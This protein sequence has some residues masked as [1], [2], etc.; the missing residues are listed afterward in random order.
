[1]ALEGTL[2]DFSLPDIFQLISLQRKSGVLTLKG[3]DDIVTVFFKD[4]NILAADSQQER[5]EHRL[6]YYLV[7]AKLLSDE[8]LK[9][10][11]D[12]QKE[13]LQRLGNILLSY[14]FI[15][16]EELQKTLQ[17]VITQKIYKLFR[18]RDGEYHFDP[19][20][21][22][23]F[24]D[25]YFS[26]IPAQGILMEA[27]RMIDEWPLIERKIPNTNIIFKKTGK[28]LQ[29]DKAEG[30]SLTA[31]DLFGD[32][33][34]FSDLF[35]A[36]KSEKVED[37]N[38]EAEDERVFRFIDGR[39]TIKDIMFDAQMTDFDVCHALNS[40][41][42]K[43]LI[44][45]LEQFKID[46]KAQWIDSRKKVEVKFPL[47]KVLLPIMIAAMILSLVM[48]NFVPLNLFV[49]YHQNKSKIEYQYQENISMNKIKRIVLAI[50]QYHLST[51]SFP[52][53]VKDLVNEGLLNN[54]A[55]IDPWGNEY[56]IK[57]T[58]NSYSIL[59]KDHKGSETLIYQGS[60]NN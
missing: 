37:E 1:M 56:Y 52:N 32:N 55:V 27:V 9:K 13:T 46:H 29:K 8:Q 20:S 6:G 28:S 35:S 31:D 59:G 60:I 47:G 19:D 10:A 21:P 15:T 50:E 17:L 53:N 30:K 34:D 14:N 33:D 49:P 5:I 11:L 43:G 22:V 23:E 40:I 7:R 51:S 45:P 58:G 24:K 44:E 4:G 42:E 18:W 16:K 54:E 12:I 36:T 57:K 25:D 38:L 48:M 26:P 3:K 2:S 41:L 39:R